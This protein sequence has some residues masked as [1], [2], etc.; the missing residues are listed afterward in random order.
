MVGFRRF[1]TA[2]DF[3]R[4]AIFG[5]FGL[6]SLATVS[7]M[8]G[9]DGIPRSPDGD[10]ARHVAYVQNFFEALSDGQWVPRLQLLPHLYPDIPTFQFYGF[11]MGLLAAPF[12]AIGCS[13]LSSLVF[14]LVIVRWAGSLSL[15][16][17]CREMRSSRI[18]ATIA[19]T[20]FLISPYVLS[21]VYGR[22]AFPEAGAHMI[23]CILFYGLIRLRS[24]NDAIAVMTIVLSVVALAL[25]HPIFL[26]YGGAAAA[27]FVVVSMPFK[28]SLPALGLL[29]GALLLAAFQWLPG[30][31]MQSNFAA[32]FT[33]ESPFS[34]AVY[35]SYSGMFGLPRSLAKTLPG[36]ADNDTRLFLTPSIAT[37]P[38]LLFLICRIRNRLALA[39]LLCLVISLTLALPPFDLW[40]GLPKST[41]AL[42]FPYRAFSFVAL[43]VSLGLGLWR[44]HRM[45]PYFVGFAVAIQSMMILIQPSPSGTIDAT[46]LPEV[47]ALLNYRMVTDHP[48]IAPHGWA[49][50]E[51]ADAGA[52][53]ASVRDAAIAEEEHPQHVIASSAVERTY[54]HGYTR[55]F[56][57]KPEAK[58]AAGTRYRIE[59][60][61]AFSPLMQVT[62]GNRPLSVAN[63]I[64]SLAVIETD[65][66][67]QPIEAHFRI[68]IEVWLMMIC[69]VALILGTRRWSRLA[70]APGTGA[71][72]DIG[73]GRMSR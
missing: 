6:I 70:A 7:K 61:L 1:F 44:G 29:L 39:L 64:D 60:P 56:Q 18:V 35:S 19:A 58:T 13:P 21:N 37:I 62:Q 12:L 25:A 20:T 68:P 40:A 14:G 30:M 26:L 73:G 16:A 22:V 41:W 15:Y 45:L 32:D 23:L 43:F 27:F 8:L 4:I 9:V 65:D 67:T 42:Q 55:I 34:A 5:Y 48:L 71:D 33:G 50:H 51:R 11:L 10:L 17:A 53:S 47:Y 24:R 52:P 54:A 36:V 66:P 3:K 2:R 31:M 72:A 49:T 28:Q 46:N 38:V 69:G 63:S 57:P 59:L